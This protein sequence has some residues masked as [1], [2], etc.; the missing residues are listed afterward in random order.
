MEQHFLGPIM[1]DLRA[2]TSSVDLADLLTPTLYVIL[3][4]YHIFC[5]SRSCLHP[6][7]S[8]VLCG[9]V[10]AMQLKPGL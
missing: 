6:L 9:E 5:P 4:S 3:R 2:H 7:D 1:R 10:G 8:H